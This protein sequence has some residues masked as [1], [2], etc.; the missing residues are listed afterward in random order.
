PLKILKVAGD[1]RDTVHYQIDVPRLKMPYRST[2]IQ[3]IG[4]A[5]FLSDGT[6]PII[7]R[8]NTKDWRIDTSYHKVPYFSKLMPIT[9][10]KLGIRTLKSETE[11]TILGMIAIKDSIEISL[12][13][14]ILSGSIDGY[15]DRDGI[16]L[17]NRELN[18][19]IYVY[20]YK[21]EY[22]NININPFTWS[23]ST[24]KT[25]DT[26]SQPILDISTN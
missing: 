11:Q 12:K 20:Y 7:H 25:I 6:V 16:L 13:Q 8:G 5:F 17:F 15:F 23:K 2:T 21:N 10:K 19:L 3:I 22:V 4:N 24:L 9:P 26:I 18:S 1:L 14:D